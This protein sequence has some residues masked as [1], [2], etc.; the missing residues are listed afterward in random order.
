[1]TSQNKTK[2]LFTFLASCLLTACGGGGS[3]EEEPKQSVYIQPQ[4]TQLKVTAIDGY[5]REAIVWLDL[6]NDGVLNNSEPSSNSGVNG[7]ATLDIPSDID[8]SEHHFWVQASAGKTFDESLNQ[9]VIRDFAMVAPKGI[10]TI[11]PITTLVYVKEKDLGDLTS[12][13]KAVASLLDVETSVLYNDFIKSKNKDLESIAA[14]L[15][16]LNLIPSS[17]EALFHLPKNT[18]DWEYRL[19]N[20]ID[21]RNEVGSQH[22]TLNATG[23]VTID[24]DADGIADEDDMDIDG[25][26]VL[27]A[28]DSFPHDASEWSDLDGDGTGDNSDQDIDGDGI[29][30]EQDENP[31]KADFFTE[32]NPGTLEFSIKKSINIKQDQWQYFSFSANSS[33]TNNILL[34]D[35]S[36]DVDLYVSDTTLPTKFEY[37]CRSNES[38]N[39]NE[40]CTVKNS[41][42]DSKTFYI[43]IFSRLDADYT[44]EISEEELALQK[45]ILLLHG[46]ASSPSTWASFIQDDQY[47]DGQCYTL[48]A[49]QQILNT[50]DSPVGDLT[51]FN[52][53]F[54]AFD[55][56][57]IYSE[58]GLDDLACNKPLGCDGDFTSLEGLGNEIEQAIEKIIEHQGE[59]IEIFLFGHSRGGLAARAYLQNN[60]S[61]YKPYVV[62]MATTGTPHLGSPLGRFYKYMADYCTPFHV[63]R[64]DNSKCEDNW[65]VVEMLNGTRTYF[66]FAVGQEYRLEMRAPGIDLLSPESTQITTLNEEALNLS[67][68]TL[69]QLVYNG[70]EFGV[71]S[72]GDG[73]F[74]N[75]DLYAY[76]SLF[77]GDHPHPDTLR[78]I[79][80]GHSRSS[81]LGDGIVP[82][83]SQRLS[84]ILAIDGIQMD[85]MGVQSSENILHTQQTSMVS[86]IHWLFEGIFKSLDWE[87]GSE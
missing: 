67:G 43:G 78:Y 22:V 28:E 79:E 20:A 72:E 77:S 37:L 15:V 87:K 23:V 7:I 40:S 70:T 11:T 29:A 62:G 30:N 27:N 56:G 16:R 81:L 25:D 55:R 17:S 52:L 63:Y 69:G 85:K 24:M 57:S 49:D 18:R 48:T 65:E 6:N 8:S 71:L 47:F 26:N 50:Y 38:D 64:Q 3:S 41:S 59:D 84:E 86:D 13:Q 21:L 2:I 14:D 83:E 5:L 19:F 51:C 9:R 32:L 45:V 33:S 61:N 4:F 1:M 44:I 80:N 82:E 58:V 36:E 34:S 35:L 68:Y 60:N 12:A 42:K 39:S 54:G 31:S 46:L 74:D 75:Y 73:I 66:G 53:E 76:Q 10:T